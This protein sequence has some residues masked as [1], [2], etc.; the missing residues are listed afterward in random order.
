MIVGND[1]SQAGESRTA[2]DRSY[3]LLVSPVT[4]A[5]AFALLERLILKGLVDKWN[6][7]LI[8]GTCLLLAIKREED[9]TIT[10]DNRAV[11]MQ[12]LSE[13]F[14][15][16]GGGGGGGGDLLRRMEFEA[17]SALS[18]NISCHEG[19]YKDHL[20]RILLYLD[21]RDSCKVWEGIR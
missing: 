1:N 3:V 14:A 20:R 2:A 8:G 21:N 13:R 5:I 11:I 9:M 4:L 18:F 17:F 19:Q 15:G 12:R 16:D 7:R 6:R 10:T